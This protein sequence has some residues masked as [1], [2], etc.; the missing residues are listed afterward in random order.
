VFSLAV[1]SHSNGR[2]EGAALALTTP[3]QTIEFV[4]E[5]LIIDSVRRWRR[6]TQD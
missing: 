3:L 6:M 1:F 2:C 5:R 4:G